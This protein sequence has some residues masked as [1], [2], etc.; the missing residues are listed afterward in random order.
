M[1][2]RRVNYFDALRGLAIILVFNVHYFGFFSQFHYFTESAVIQKISTFLLCGH[3]GVDIFFALSGYLIVYSLDK[4]KP[5]LKNFF[6]NRLVRLFPAHLLVSLYIY[7]KAVSFPFADLLINLTFLAPLFNG[8]KLLNHVTWSLYYEWIFY[9][10]IYFSFYFSQML[11]G[12]KTILYTIFIFSFLF[13]IF[14]L[15]IDPWRCTSFISGAACYCY[16]DQI[17]I[18]FAKKSLRLSVIFLTLLVSLAWPL[19]AGVFAKNNISLEVY[20]FFLGLFNGIFILAIPNSYILKKIFSNKLLIYLGDISYSFYLIHSFVIA[21]L[22]NQFVYRFKII[23]S[24]TQIY[25]VYFLIFGVS[26]GISHLSY[27]YVEL[28][29]LKFKK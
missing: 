17:N 18:L 28:R 4:K 29:F 3:F 12:K 22:L 7:T 8:V 9:F 5:N 10:C 19:Y 6:Y 23:S 26:V 16:R 1:E 24:P 27:K 15:N 2:L 11:I 25:L 21:E 20:Y 14:Q 13:S